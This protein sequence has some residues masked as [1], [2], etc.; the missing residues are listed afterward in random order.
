MKGHDHSSVILKSIVFGPS[1]NSRLSLFYVAY[2]E[3]PTGLDFHS[4]V[5]ETR[6]DAG[7]RMTATISKSE[8]QGTN[9][10]RRWVSEVHSLDPKQAAAIIQ[11][12]EADSPG[13]IFEVL[14]TWRRWDLLFALG[15]ALLIALGFMLALG[16]HGYATAFTSTWPFV[17]LWFLV[18]VFNLA[19]SRSVISPGS[20][21]D[22]GG[23]AFGGYVIATVMFLPLAFGASA[24]GVSLGRIA[25]RRRPPSSNAA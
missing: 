9:P 19:S 17:L 25:G 12:A 8:F 11:V 16:G 10:R 14:Y 5:W 18:G 13:E 21:L 4:L 24:F 20:A 3:M 1:G 7:W 6:T 2:E 15:Y 22:Q 23:G